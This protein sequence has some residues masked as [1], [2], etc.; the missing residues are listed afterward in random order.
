MELPTAEVKKVIDDMKREQALWTG[1]YVDDHVT[2][3]LKWS[4]EKYN[5]QVFD[6]PPRKKRKSPAH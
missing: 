3:A 2:E 5:L 4:K 6:L 1:T